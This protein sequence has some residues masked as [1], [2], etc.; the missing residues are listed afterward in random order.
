MTCYIIDS[1]NFGVGV[2]ESGSVGSVGWWRSGELGEC[3]RDPRRLKS[4]QIKIV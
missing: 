1:I 4:T 2:G 3:Q